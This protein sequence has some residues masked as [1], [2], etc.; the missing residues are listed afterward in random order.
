MVVLGADAA[1]RGHRRGDGHGG[2]D[3]RPGDDRGR[4]GGGRRRGRGG[5]GGGLP[6]GGQVLLLWVHVDGVQTHLSCAAGLPLVLHGCTHTTRFLI[7]WKIENK[8]FAR[9]FL[10]V[11]DG[12]KLTVFVHAGLQTLLQPTRLA[13][14]PMG[15]VHRAHPRPG[16]A[17]V[18]THKPL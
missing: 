18:H 12:D 5:R 6:G 16:L 2:G 11:S 9:D 7:I 13:L 4:G 10:R 3:V 8:V 17:P 14:V 1:L 15:F